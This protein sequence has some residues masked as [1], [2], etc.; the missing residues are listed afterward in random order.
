[1]RLLQRQTDHQQDCWRII[2]KRFPPEG[3]VFLVPG[4]GEKKWRARGPEV[5][6]VR[7]LFFPFRICP[8][9]FACLLPVEG[10]KTS[11]YDASA[12]LRIQMACQV[13]V[14][15]VPL[16][17]KIPAF[18]AGGGTIMEEGSPS[19]YLFFTW[20]LYWKYAI[21][22][23]SSMQKSARFGFWKDSFTGE[24]EEARREEWMQYKKREDQ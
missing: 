22:I 17:P 4:K 13:W 12:A 19:F 23:A 14:F 11:W 3:N 20:Y 10:D 6:A 8:Q 9:R 5:L 7:T 15:C 16:V 18:P 2:E 1:M 21:I 24:Y